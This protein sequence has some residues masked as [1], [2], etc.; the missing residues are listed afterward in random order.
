VSMGKIVYLCIIFI[1]CDK[2]VYLTIILYIKP[3][4]AI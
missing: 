2:R 1:D 4:E 3:K